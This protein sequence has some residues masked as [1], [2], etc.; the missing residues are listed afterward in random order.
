LKSE[1]KGMYEVSR[2]ENENLISL[3]FLTSDSKLKAVPIDVG[4]RDAS[5]QIQSRPG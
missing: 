2:N 5:I 3:S 4:G 1:N